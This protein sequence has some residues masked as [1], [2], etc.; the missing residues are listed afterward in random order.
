MKQKLDLKGEEMGA[1][2]SEASLDV[3]GRR[4]QR[5]LW[6]LLLLLLHLMSLKIAIKLRLLS[7]HL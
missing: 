5:V 7:L 1:P 2:I 4:L 6:L 3:V